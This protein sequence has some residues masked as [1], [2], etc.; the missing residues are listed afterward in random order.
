MHSYYMATYAELHPHSEQVVFTKTSLFG[1]VERH[2]VDIRNLEKI[3]AEEID[4]ELMW[5]VHKMDDE[6]CFKDCLTGEIFVFD[7]DG[8]WNKDALEHPLLH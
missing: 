4:H 7:K 5:I 2:F 1:K 3:D 6:L 8:V